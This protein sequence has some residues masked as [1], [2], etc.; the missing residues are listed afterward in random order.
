MPAWS[1]CIDQHSV[2]G[3]G[4]LDRG[5]EGAE[6][7]RDTGTSDARQRQYRGAGPRRSGERTAFPGQVGGVDR[8]DLVE[9][10]DFGLVGEAMTVIG[11][12]PANR[13]IG[14]DDVLLGAV[15]QMEDDGAAL[16]MSHEAGAEPGALPGPPA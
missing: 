2:A 1:S 11:E 7:R 3:A 16:D 13:P 4:R 14:G 5:M 6:H 8:I 12:L 15:D 10:D 9:A